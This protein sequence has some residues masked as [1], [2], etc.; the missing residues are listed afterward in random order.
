M[1]TFHSGGIASVGGDITQGLPR[2]EEIF[3]RRIPKN[4]AVVSTA[5]GVVSTIEEGEKENRMVVLA[6]V[7]GSKKS[8]E[9]EYTV[10]V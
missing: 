6:E 9:I 7:G 4:G 2:I 10:P 8:N 5:D 1:R 3:E